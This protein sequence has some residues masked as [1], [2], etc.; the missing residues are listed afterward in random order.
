MKMHNL[1]PG[2]CSR[3]EALVIAGRI[4]AAEDNGPGIVEECSEAR[5]SAREHGGVEVLRQMAMLKVG[6]P[7]GPAAISK[8]PSNWQLIAVKYNRIEKVDSFS[9][10]ESGHLRVGLRGGFGLRCRL[11]KW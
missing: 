4:V 10:Q 2:G 8:R 3:V 11:S 7:S 6:K 1:G 5:L 9:R